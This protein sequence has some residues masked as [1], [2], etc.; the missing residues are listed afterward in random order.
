[1]STHEFEDLSIPKWKYGPPEMSVKTYRVYSSAKEFTLV[2]A[3][4]VN[5]AL[6]KCGIAKAFM[7]KLGVMDDVTLLDR[8][9]LRPDLPP[10]V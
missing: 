6:E 5:I 7:I 1:M 2:E 8:N 4:N 3:E 10:V 9:M